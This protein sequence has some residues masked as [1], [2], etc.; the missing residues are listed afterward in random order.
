MPRIAFQGEPGAFSEEAI[1]RALGDRATPVPRPEFHDVA[2]AIAAGAAEY[3]M[4][5]VENTIAGSVI[6]SYDILASAA[7]EAFGEVVVPIH[8]CVLAVPGTT[9]Q[10]V[11]RIT[12][13]PVA[14][15]QC[16]RFLRRSGIEAVASL[17]TAG[18][19]RQVA[20]AGDPAVAA[21]AGRGAAGRYGLQV[22]VADV[23]D[24]P[25][26]QTRFLL[27]GSPGDRLPGLPGS[28]PGSAERSLLLVE[29]PNRPGGLVGVLEPFAARGVNLT[30]IEARPGAEPWTYRFFL[31]IEADCRDPSLAP[32]LG[33]VERAASRTRLLGCY[34]RL[35][36]RDP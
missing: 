14:L 2:E 1:H 23:E 20:Q 15:A 17:D 4:L 25:D 22:L 9:L 21:I 36:P 32:V 26:N 16:T 27:L 34:S 28:A 18:A 10:D 5:P 24:R 7:L 31:E 3:A 11:R 6:P 13:H 30:K 29:T 19:A 8:H 12:S 35:W 33:A